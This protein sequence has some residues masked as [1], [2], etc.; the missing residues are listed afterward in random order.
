MGKI[1]L[2]TQLPKD[3]F[4]GAAMSGPQTEGAWQATGKLPNLWDRWSNLNITDFYNLVGSYGGND[5]TRRRD[6]D[7]QIF[8]DLGLDSVRTSIQW[9]RLMDK[10]GKLNQA[11]ADYYHE[12]F[13]AF[14]KA[15]IDVFVNLYHFDMPAYLYDRGG[16]ENREVVE[17]YA[18]YARA[19][20]DQF[21]ISW[22]NSS[23]A[24]RA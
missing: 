11:G 13:A 18:N 5:F 1:E 4:L 24:A 23:N 21:L 6:E 16:W 2:P 3:F 10:D 20:F 22:P 19:A 12:L 15:G 9:S 17:A 7:I 14:A 8:K